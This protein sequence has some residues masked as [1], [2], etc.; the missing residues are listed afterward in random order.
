MLE[1]TVFAP[2]VKKKKKEYLAIAF[3]VLSV[4]YCFTDDL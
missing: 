1:M 2:L 4:S 3:V